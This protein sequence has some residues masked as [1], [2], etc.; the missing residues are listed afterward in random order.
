MT[1]N[2]RASTTLAD[3]GL[4]STSPQRLSATPLLSFL[5][6]FVLVSFIL[7]AGGTAVGGFAATAEME[8]AASIEARKE[9]VRGRMSVMKQ[10]QERHEERKRQELAESARKRFPKPGAQRRLPLESELPRV[11]DASSQD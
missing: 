2:R 4:R 5:G 9:V 7:H 1:F 6:A 10:R 11:E 3:P 8:A